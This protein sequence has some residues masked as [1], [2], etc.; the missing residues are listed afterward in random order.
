MELNLP[1]LLLF[2]MNIF[3]LIE[4]QLKVKLVSL[5]KILNRKISQSSAELCFNYNFGNIIPKIFISVSKFNWS[6]RDQGI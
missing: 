4:N 6:L 2:L 1:V 3:F 5:E